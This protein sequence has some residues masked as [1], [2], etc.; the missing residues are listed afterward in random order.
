LFGTYHQLLL[1]RRPHPLQR[2]PPNNPPSNPPSNLRNTRLPTRAFMIVLGQMKRWIAGTIVPLLQ[3]ACVMRTVMAGFVVAKLVTGA[4]LGVT[5]TTGTRP[6]YVL[7]SP[8]RLP[9]L[10]PRPPL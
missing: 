6:M 10:P 4:N 8:S 7:A 3:V 2:S 9:R 5:A 1:H